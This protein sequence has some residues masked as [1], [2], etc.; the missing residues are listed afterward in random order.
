M[1]LVGLC[2]LGTFAFGAVAAGSASSALA[3]APEV[4]RCVPAA[5]EII[6]GKRH[7]KG[8]YKN[9]ACTVLNPTNEG[10]WEWVPGPGPNPGFV[11][12]GTPEE[13]ATLETAKGRKITCTNGLAEGELTGPKSEK[14]NL[15]LI[16]CEDTTSKEKC[17]NFTP[18]I[19]EPKPTPGKIQT[20]K[21]VGG[22]GFINK[23]KKQVGWDIKP[24]TGPVLAYF[25]CGETPLT[26]TKYVLEG[27]YITRIYPVNKAIEEFLQFYVA[28]GGKQIPTSFEGGEPDTLSV[29][30]IEGV[31][32][33]TES[34][35]LSELELF[36]TFDTVV[37][38]TVV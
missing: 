32:E 7:W 23:A 10:H 35:G 13:T 29:K 4:G 8:V 26:G 5:N 17:Q 18:E 3:A 12:Q 30:V 9:R 1:R 15:Q 36:N 14:V 16:G 19:G 6:A 37:F 28:K 38:N 22:L 31:S 20:Q 27:S 33:R 21:L 25:E 11:G 34:I 24:E 2:L